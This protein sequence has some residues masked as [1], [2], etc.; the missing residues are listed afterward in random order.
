MAEFIMKYWLEFG[1]GL[2]SLA[3]TA[4]VKYLHKQDKI[5]KN[6]QDAIKKGI[7]ALLRDRIIEQYN[8]YM[9]RKYIPIYAMDNVE[10][11]YREYHALGGNGTITELYE[12]LK[13][14]PHRKEDIGS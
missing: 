4:L 3:L 9:E 12:D 7:Q 6:E 10:A 14:L 13:D 8:K 2:I 5:R 11:M 1:F